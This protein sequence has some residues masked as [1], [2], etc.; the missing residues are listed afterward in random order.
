[1][2]KKCIVEWCNQEWRITRWYCDKHYQRIKRY[3]DETIVK[4]FIGEDR[5]NNPIYDIYHAMKQRCYY[6]KHKY[7]SYYWW[8]WITIHQKRLWVNWFTN[9]LKDMYPRPSLKHS[10]DRID[11]NWNYCKENC[12][13]ATRH[14][15]AGNKRSSNKTVWVHYTKSESRWR[16]TLKVDKKKVLNNKFRTEQGAVDA[17]KE[18]ELKYLWRYL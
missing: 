9:F 3:W 8:R 12:R 14:E 1:M 7:Y 16:A 5:K 13:W 11:S 15:Q 17:R 2:E 4:S 18:A 6:I 10:I